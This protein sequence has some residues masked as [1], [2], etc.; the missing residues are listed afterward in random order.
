MPC[1]FMHPL[2]TV[3]CA[4][5]LGFLTTSNNCIVYIWFQE[6]YAAPALLFV[7]N[8]QIIH[9]LLV[10]GGLSRLSLVQ[11]RLIYNLQCLLKMLQLICKYIYSQFSN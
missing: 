11:D 5:A 7:W 3:Q 9:A 2:L 1:L 4:Y 6:H 8:Q 10:S